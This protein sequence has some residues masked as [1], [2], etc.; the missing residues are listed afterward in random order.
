MKPNNALFG[1]KFLG[2][3]TM[4]KKAGTVVSAFRTVV[5]ICA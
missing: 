4:K 5:A 2:G 1:N 3:N